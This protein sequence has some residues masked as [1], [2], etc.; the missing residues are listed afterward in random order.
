MHKVSVF[1]CQVSATALCDSDTS[2]ETNADGFVE[3]LNSGGRGCVVFGKTTHIA[4]FV[5]PRLT[6]N[7]F[8]FQ[9]LTLPDAGSSP[10]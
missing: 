1:R 9:S 5:I 2:Y 8:Y 10:A 3:S 7:P 4:V 6:R